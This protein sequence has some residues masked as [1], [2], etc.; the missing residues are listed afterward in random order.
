MGMVGK[1]ITSRYSLIFDV[2][3]YWKSR[4]MSYW[5]SY[6]KWR[7]R[8]LLA[9]TDVILEVMS[10][11]ILEVM[12]DGILEVMSD[13]LL[14]F[15]SDGILEVISDGILD[16]MSSGILDVICPKPKVSVEN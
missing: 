7:P 12:S 3:S 6:E 15:M 11:V 2:L 13:G 1:Q 16:V 8:H 10:D 4:P 9:M 14:K 5:M